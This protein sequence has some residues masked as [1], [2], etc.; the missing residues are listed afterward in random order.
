MAVTI[1]HIAERVGVSKQ[2]VSY[3]LNN[4]QG[5]VSEATRTKILAAAQD[6]GYQANWR[7]R[8]FAKQRSNIVG[9]VYSRPRQYLEQTQI[10]PSLVHWLAE[11]DYELLLIPAAGP[12]ENWGHKLRDG[13]VD[14][15]FVSHPVPVGLDRFVLEHRLPTVLANLR[16]ERSIPQVYFDDAD[17][18]RQAVE[19]LRGLGHTRI[20]Y[21]CSPK[22]EG[23]H[24]S[25]DVRRDAYVAEMKR[26]GL[27]NQVTQIVGQTDDAA[28]AFASQPRD[29]R[30][31]AVIAYN[32]SD[33]I[34]LQRALWR[35]DLLIGRDLSLMG[36]NDDASRDA[37]PPL[38]TVALPQDELA[39]HCVDLLLDRI[40]TPEAADDPPRLRMVLDE[41]LIVR[42][43]TLPP[44]V[45]A[46]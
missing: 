14:G 41:K 20:A 45:A 38:T 46:P 2:A 8:S 42:E 3:A 6:M 13:R 23:E 28:A 25:N 4:R 5:Q 27:D 15:C 43:S 35:H 37:T 17:G 10:V 34:M 7:A 31:T 26:A 33:A 12:V 19:H 39:R 9:L 11:M 24:Y 29:A 21:Y 40:A 44:P 16:S 22:S 36:F 30:P 32:D 1:Q 18:M